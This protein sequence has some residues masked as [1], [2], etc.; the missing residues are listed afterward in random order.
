MLFCVSVDSPANARVKSSG[1]WTVDA[2]DGE[3]AI[4]ELLTY[5]SAKLWPAGSVW[6]L[7][8]LCADCPYRAASHDD[9]WPYR[10]IHCNGQ[11]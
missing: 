3:H 10:P 6:K 2:E 4:A 5:V 7:S 11:R 8:V 9:G 1:R